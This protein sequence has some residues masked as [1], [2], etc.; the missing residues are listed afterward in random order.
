MLALTDLSVSFRGCP[1][2]RNLSFDLASGETLGLVGESGS[3][4]SMTALALMGL[5]PPGFE[6]KGSIRL[7]GTELLGLP[8]KALCRLRGRAMAMIFQEPMTALNPVLTVGAQI[9]EGL[10][11]HGLMEPRAA[12]AEA[13]RLMERVGL[14]DPARRARSYPHELSGGQRQRAMIAMAISCR[15]AVLIADEPTS[16]LDVSLQVEILALLREIRAETG[17][18]MIFISHDLTLIS[19]MADR[20]L[21]LYGGLAMESGPV[22]P[23]IDRPAHPYTQGLI[24]AIPRGTAHTHRLSPIRGQV[25]DLASL[26]PGCPFAGRCTLGDAHCAG[27]PPPLRSGLTQIHCHHA[28]PVPA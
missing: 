8:D 24:A 15:P 6:A 20:A 17:M 28:E 18:A 27:T 19:A 3:G 23:V 11:L 9:A 12:M 7:R 5:L 2:L 22:R 14:P 16:A 4:K 26:P 21:V 10:V 25:P 13:I 1:V